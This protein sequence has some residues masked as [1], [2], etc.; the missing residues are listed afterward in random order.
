MNFKKEMLRRGLHGIPQGLAIGY[1]IS[2]IAS[3]MMGDG[4][5]YLASGALI[6]QF[7]SEIAAV[8]IQAIFS[9]IVGSTFGVISVIWEID[10]WSIFKQT[11]I[12]FT[13]SSLIFL[14]ISY[15]LQWMHRSL[16]GFVI[17]FAVFLFIFIVTW[18]VQYFVWR[19]RISQIN[20]RL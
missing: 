16:Q 3:I 14:P 18:L 1:V 9:A 2:I 8:I 10:E 12:Y 5:F 13:I 4:D 15:Y 6:E 17:Y 20:E 7:G 11:G 19:K